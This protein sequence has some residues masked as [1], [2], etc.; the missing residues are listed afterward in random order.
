MPT[1]P[2]WDRVTLGPRRRRRAMLRRLAELDRLDRLEARGP[3]YG[4]SGRG[5][6]R[7]R[8]WLIPAGS[9]VV[10]V[11]VVGLLSPGKLPTPLADLFRE[12]TS[13]PAVDAQGP[14]SWLQHQPG[15]PSVPVAWSPCR[16]IHVELNTRDAP[17][18]AEDL[19]KRAMKRVSAATGL[20]FVYDGTT[21]RRPDED[22]SGSGSNGAEPGSRP[23]V[24]VS[25]ASPKEVPALAGRVA[26]VGGGVSRGVGDGV[27]FY[28]TG[29][30]T[31][32]AGAFRSMLRRNGGVAEA[33]AIVLHE[34][35]HLVGLGHVTD[36]G[37]LMF[38]EN[39]G[40]QDFGPGDLEGLARLGEGPCD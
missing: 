40:Q 34:F 23:P 8:G 37:E 15:A 5:A 20:R 3:S 31:L 24:L 19:T 26:G 14:H 32:D 18:Q 7:A 11:G 6:E 12:R 28:I 4:R 2:F 21:K 10:V 1:G 30:V 22:G 29:T 35:G 9:L 25:W 38:K 39:T 13:P 27:R 33:R 17:R 36:R 16:V